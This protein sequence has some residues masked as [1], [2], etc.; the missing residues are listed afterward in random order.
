MVGFGGG[1]LQ[2]NV[3]ICIVLQLNACSGK[4]GK[5]VVNTIHKGKGDVAQLA[6]AL[7][8]QPRGRGFESHLL[9]KNDYN[10]LIY[11]RLFFC[12]KK[13]DL[14]SFILPLDNFCKFK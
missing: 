1:F 10:R 5:R 6:R 9:H 14:L 11:R 2:L 13:G 4:R 12:D 7:G 3:Y 8:W